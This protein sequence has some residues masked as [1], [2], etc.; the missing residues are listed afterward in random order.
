MQLTA[1]MHFL[2]S[3]NLS[4]LGLRCWAGHYDCCCTKKKINAILESFYDQRE[5]AML[6]GMRSRLGLMMSR[7]ED[8]VLINQWLSILHRKGAD[9][10]SSFRYLME[11]KND[12]SSDHHLADKLGL[13][14]TIGFWL[15]G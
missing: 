4:D 14:V 10:N 12:G 2:P 7:E 9:Y 1:Y 5:K 6:C 11:W 3:L 15:S 8:S 13:N